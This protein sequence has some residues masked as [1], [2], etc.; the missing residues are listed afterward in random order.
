VKEPFGPYTITLEPALIPPQVHRPLNPPFSTQNSGS[1]T[2]FGGSQFE[3]HRGVVLQHAIVSCLHDKI[4]TIVASA[5]ER[6][7]QQR[8][9]IFGLLFDARACALAFPFRRITLPRRRRRRRVDHVSGCAAHLD[10]SSTHLLTL[11]GATA[12]HRAFS[13]SINLSG[14]ARRGPVRAGH[15]SD[16]GIVPGTSRDSAL[17][18]GRFAGP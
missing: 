7:R 15:L 1:A 3:R 8:L 11:G 10:S 16:A 6:T 18:A 17:G 2:V 5:R 12:P 13:T 9:F 4:L 14:R